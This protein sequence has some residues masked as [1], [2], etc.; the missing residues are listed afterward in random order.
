[1]SQP[2]TPH[3]T[4][5]IQ[6]WTRESIGDTAETWRNLLNESRKREG[7]RTLPTTIPARNT[8]FRQQTDELKTAKIAWDARLRKAED[9]NRVLQAQVQT[10]Q[11]NF[12]VQQQLWK[13]TLERLDTL[14]GKVLT[15]SIQ[16]W[17]DGVNTK[18]TTSADTGA[19]I[20]HADISSGK[21]NIPETTISDAANISA[22][23]S[24]LKLPKDPKLDAPPPFEGDP[25]QTEGWVF[26]M[27]QY[28]N[29]KPRELATESAR[30]AF[31][32]SRLK[33]KVLDWWIAIQK[34]S[35]QVHTASAALQVIESTYADRGAREKAF[36]K[37]QNLKH[38]SSITEFFLEAERLNAQVQLPETTLRDLLRLRL[39]QDIRFALAGTPQDKLEYEFWRDAVIEKALAQEIVRAQGPS[40]TT[41]T[42]KKSQNPSTLTKEDI[43]VSTRDG[44]FARG[45]CI[46]C[47]MLG[48][49]ARDCRTGWRLNTP[50]PNQKRAIEAASPQAAKKQKGNVLTL[51]DQVE[52]PEA[53]LSEEEQAK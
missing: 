44:R 9:T 22:I 20:S 15:K 47:G 19:D 3:P 18:S 48:H 23:Y 40:S 11:A 12:G 25:K 6:P 21:A 43:P 1:M 39:R 2:D 7:P 10:L 36:Q 17:L 27:R 29:M 5:S 14:E 38:Q 52:F 26:Q 51:E 46:K 42:P 35:I 16:T 41:F 32:G 34:T 8:Q 50:P 45:A 30:L 33:G 4:S 49:R 28:I 13:T 53:Q 37:L 24:N 31:I